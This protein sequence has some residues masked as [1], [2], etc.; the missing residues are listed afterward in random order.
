MET[1]SKARWRRLLKR[2][3]HTTHPSKVDVLQSDPKPTKD[4][5]EH[6]ESLAA[7]NSNASLGAFPV[8]AAATP[9]DAPFRRSANS[10]NHMVEIITTNILS[11]NSVRRATPKSLLKVLDRSFRCSSCALAECSR[12]M[13]KF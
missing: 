4:T 13:L 7:P 2:A 11:P 8:L 12:D 5:A 3:I 9:G 10:L 6:S 1:D